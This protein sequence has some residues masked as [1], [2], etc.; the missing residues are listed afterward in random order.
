MLLRILVLYLGFLSGKVAESLVKPLRYN[1]TILTHLD[2]GGAQNR[3]EGIVSIDILAQKATR[4]IFMNSR[5]LILF[6]EK[7]WLL[8]WASGKRIS[9]IGIKKNAKKSNE[10]ILTLKN[11]LNIGEVYTIHMFFTGGLNRPQRNGFFF[12]HYGKTPQVF[13]AVTRLEPDYAHTVFPCFDSP[14]IRTTFNITV[15]HHEKFVALSNMPAIKET[16]HQEIS[17][18]VWTTF[19]QSPPMATHQVMWA[20]HQ[21]Q[22]VSSGLTASG[23]KITIW[24]RPQMKEQL[25][26]AAKFTQSLLSNYESLFAYP[27]PNGPDWGGKFDHV[28]LP[29]Y[30]EADSSKGLLVYGEEEVDSN[31]ETDEK[32]QEMLGELLVRQWLGLLVSSSDWDGSYVRDGIN[33]YLALHVVAMQDKETHDMSHLLKTRLEI[34]YS[35]SLPDTKSLLT[36][37]TESSHKMFRKYKMAQ[38]I[39]MIRTVFGDKVFFE[40]LREFF[41]EYANN[42]ASNRQLWEVLQREARRSY[43]LP[44]GLVLTTIMDSWLTQP[45][46]PILTVLRDS[47]NDKVTITQSRY[48]QYNMAITSK[49]CWWLPVIYITKTLTLPQTE[50]T[51]CQNKKADVLRLSKVVDPKNWLLVNVDAPVPLRVLYDLYN[52]RLIAEALAEKYSQIPELSRAQLVDDALNLGWSGQLHYNTTLNVIKYLSKETSVIVWETALISLEKLQSIMRMST[53]YRIFKLFMQKLIEQTFKVTLKSIKSTARTSP[54][55]SSP[56]ESPDNKNAPDS[57]II[58]KEGQETIGK[59]LPTIMYRLAC[60]FEVK[61]CL[62][63]ARQQFKTAVDQKSSSSIPEGIRETV[64]CFGI[65][66]GFEDDWLTVRDMFLNA[67]DEKEKGILLNSLSCT[68]EYWT[69]QKLLNW[70]LDR[71]KVSKSLTASFLTAVMRTYLGFYMGNRFLTDKMEEIQRQ[72]SNNE[73][74]SILNPFINSVTSNVELAALNSLLQNKL[75]S[76]ATSSITSMLQPASDRVMWRKYKYYELLNAIRNNTL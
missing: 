25:A 64:L 26:K 23:E 33:Y 12:G 27:L 49:N 74:K 36:K 22:K 50:W 41:Q 44:A 67:K 73:L 72:F 37:V 6:L 19:M 46:Y 53:G 35:D 69:M 4:S 9:T 28:V 38:I 66:N 30:A 62:S 60:Q 42:S 48:H 43:E 58:P 56:I 10:V 13:Y 31:D 29:N 20:L 14:S 52:W 45:G 57:K 65:R 39:H 16:P 7:T 70:S 2:G 40:G 61:E 68:T 24:A 15:V 5:D 76:S 3:Y 63:D 21:L 8:R 32:L 47:K 11:N 55:T 59:S 34:M 17:H 71:K 1:L 75:P 54:E 18:Y 51:G